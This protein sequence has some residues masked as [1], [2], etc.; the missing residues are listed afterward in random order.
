MSL[1]DELNEE[2]IVCVKHFEGPALVL[3]GAGSGKTRVIT[4]RIAYLNHFY[5]IPLY[6]IVAVTFTNRAADEMKERIR[7]LLKRDP[8]EL[9]IGTIHSFCARILRVYADKIGYNNNFSIYDT[10]E[11]K[12]VLKNI[13]KKLEIPEK[14]ISIGY[15]QNAISHYKNRLLNYKSIVEKDEKS[16]YLKKIFMEY[17]SEMFF[18]NAMDFDDL[19]YNIAR[20]LKEFPDIRERLGEKFR[21]I[22]ID[23][24][25]DTN[26]A[27][28]VIF[29]LLAEKHNNIFV[30]GDDDQS[31]YSFRGADINNILNFEKDFKNVKIYKLE[32]NYRSTGY[33]LDAAS[34][35]IKNNLLRMGKTLWTD[36]PAGEKIKIFSAQTDIEEADK[37][38]FNI[39][40]ESKK[41]DYSEMAVFYRTNAQ[42]RPIEEALIKMNIPYKI[43]KGIV[44]YERKEIKDILAYMRF[45]LNKNDVTSFLRIINTPSR[46]IGKVTIDNILI[47]SEKRGIPVWDAAREVG[48]I[49]SKVEDFVEMIEEMGKIKKPDKLLKKIIEET[50]IIRLLEEEGTPESLSRIE[51]IEEL[52]RSI[53]YFMER[54]PEAEL[55]DFLHEVSLLTDI[56][57]TEKGNRVSLMTIHNA[58]GLEFPVV[59][60]SGL[61]E[62]IFPHYLSYDSSGIEEERR[63]FYV[64]ITRAKEKAYISFYQTR[65]SNYRSFEDFVCSRFIEELPP[66]AVEIE[67]EIRRK[68]VKSD[69]GGKIVSHP[70]FGEGIIIKK[71]GDNFLISFNGVVKKIKKGFFTIK[72]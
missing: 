2:Q 38:A 56:D 20:I 67:G 28:Y 29:K 66:D 42:S 68:K 46:G 32:R 39:L 65:L 61:V 47:T 13:F 37:I 36:K 1:L 64:G 14:K 3:A 34:Y 50:G 33:I 6:N 45:I 17:E 27:Q 7:N 25:Q 30:V 54:N 40:K 52:G 43:Y 59:F 71:D 11:Q 51:N 10:D 60:I 19:L 21:F 26:H 48:E 22:L 44:F 58:K 57:R 9:N 23:E 63:L 53:E 35:M 18:Y 4:Y 24:Y 41:Y 72:E 69:F 5:K 70:V 49:N 55:A 31:I 62:G 16:H 15:V 12:Q 8:S